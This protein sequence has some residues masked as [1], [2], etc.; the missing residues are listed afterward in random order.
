MRFPTTEPITL[1]PDDPGMAFCQAHQGEP[2]RQNNPQTQQCVQGSHRICTV[3]ILK[4]LRKDASCSCGV[5]KWFVLGGS[6]QFSTASRFTLASVGDSRAR[7][8]Q[9]PRS[10][11]LDFD[12]PAQA[13]VC[14]LQALSRSL[15]LPLLSSSLPALYSLLRMS[16]LCAWQCLFLTFSSFSLE[17]CIPVVLPP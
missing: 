2:K 12:C 8:N 10:L 1:A 14:V 7:P 17:F 13:I 4:G 6:S 16:L 3:H 9:Q 15:L 5:T 11:Q